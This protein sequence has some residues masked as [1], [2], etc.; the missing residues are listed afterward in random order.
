MRL[1]RACC[2]LVLLAAIAL[3]AACSDREVRSKGGTGD[4]TLHDRLGAAADAVAA[5]NAIHGSKI[6][7]CATL[8]RAL[9]SLDSRPSARQFDPR[10]YR[11]L[12]EELL[13]AGQAGC[14]GKEALTA[15]GGAA[16]GPAQRIAR[17]LLES[18]PEVALIALGSSPS[19][20]A[21]LLRRSE[22]LFELGR[23]KEAREALSGALALHDDDEQRA[24][25]ARLSLLAGEPERAL[26]LCGNR[27]A[28]ALQALRVGALAALGR[29]DEVVNEL[30]RAPLHLHE[31]LAEHAARFAPTPLLMTSAKDAP[32]PLLLAVAAAIKTEDTAAS[33]ALLAK[34]SALVPDDADVQMQLAEALEAAGRPREAVAP[35]DRAAVIAPATERPILVPIRLLAETGDRKAARQ[36]AA[37]LEAAA[38][39]SKSADDWR[40]ASLAHKY[41]GDSA[42]AAVLAHKA[43]TARAGDGRLTS[44]LAARLEEANRKDQAAQILATLLV[45]GAHGR[46][47][48]RHELM[49]RLLALVDAE[50]LERL[51]AA[52]TCSPVQPEDLK[53][54]LAE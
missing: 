4:L 29:Y 3:S 19:S 54:H 14:P 47:W 34:A 38:K 28:S 49:A 13:Q 25:A 21:V 33:I 20:P 10:S 15:L 40:M 22:L 30:A 5:S 2:T 1:F 9:A 18:D 35:W 12:I 16:A 26:E 17:S 52:Q 50:Q 27:S 39:T 53:S 31:E 41:A 42:R 44:E 43:V 37:R 6:T 7:S 51:V 48:H 23:A 46:P 11:G 32:A 8:E 36:R 24:T 45:C